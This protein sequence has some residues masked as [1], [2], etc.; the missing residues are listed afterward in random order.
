MVDFIQTRTYTPPRA[1]ILFTTSENTRSVGQPVNGISFSH[2]PLKAHCLGEI[3]LGIECQFVTIN[4]HR[5]NHSPNGF[6]LTLKLVT[7]SELRQFYLHQH[8][9]ENHVRRYVT[10]QNLSKLNESG[11]FPKSRCGKVS[12]WYVWRSTS[13][14]TNRVF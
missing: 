12:G 4:H 6:T 11:L 2:N 8:S 13:F 14:C 5:V 9:I 1:F 3:G 10:F 7:Y